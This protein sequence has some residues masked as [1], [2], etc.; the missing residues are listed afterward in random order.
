MGSLISVANAARAHKR[1]VGLSVIAMVLVARVIVRWRSTRMVARRHRRV[2]G[3]RFV[4]WTDIHGRIDQYVPASSKDHARAQTKAIE[5]CC[6]GP[7]DFG[8]S[9]WADDYLNVVVAKGDRFH[10][11]EAS[12][13]GNVACISGEIHRLNRIHTQESEDGMLRLDVG[14]ESLGW[15]WEA[16]DAEGREALRSF[17]QELQR[18]RDGTS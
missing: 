16:H 4:S 5:L 13:S 14:H 6:G 18:R 2:S 15:F 1:R 10:D 11:F 7:P 8:Y 9:M 3:G 12:E 17:A